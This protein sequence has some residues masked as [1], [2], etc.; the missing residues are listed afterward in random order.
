MFNYT[1][2]MNTVCA[3]V[4]TGPL[5][6]QHVSATSPLVVAAFS[7]LRHA[8]C[9]PLQHSTGT[10]NS[11]SSSNSSSNDSARDDEWET[12]GGAIYR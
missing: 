4:I 6:V 12:I 11:S 10:N 2:S 1:D 3:Y 9:T 8:R 5:A 7:A